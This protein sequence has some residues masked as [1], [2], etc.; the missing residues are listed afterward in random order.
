MINNPLRRSFPPSLSHV[1]T[2]NIRTP[3]LDMITP[4]FQSP[5]G[6]GGVS[7]NIMDKSAMSHHTNYTD[8]VASQSQVQKMLLDEKSRSE[9]HKINY[10]KLKKQTDQMSSEFKT[11]SY[12]LQ[13]KNEEVA[14]IKEQFN[15]VISGLESELKRKNQI[16]DELEGQALTEEKLESIKFKV[17]SDLQSTFKRRMLDMEQDVEKY[18]NDFNKLRHD[19]SFL[20][21]EYEKQAYDFAKNLED[22]NFKFVSEKN[23]IL[24][25][26][27]QIVRISEE[28]RKQSEEK[29]KNNV[30][31]N[32]YLK[33]RLISQ[34]SMNEE[35]QQQIDKLRND[36]DLRERGHIK[37]ITDHE[38]KIKIMELEKTSLVNQIEKLKSEANDQVNKMRDRDARMNEIERDNQ[39]LTHDNEVLTHQIS[40]KDGEIRLQM[41]K[42]ANYDSEHTLK[43][44]EQL[45]DAITEKEVANMQVEKF[46]QLMTSKEREFT[47]R[48]EKGKESHSI[49][50]NKVLEEKAELESKL[51]TSESEVKTLSDT[52]KSLKFDLNVSTNECSNLKEEISKLKLEMEQQKSDL[53]AKELEVRERVNEI[54]SLDKSSEEL[55]F[56]VKNLSSQF[57]TC[58]TAKDS[59]EKQN[60]KM[61]SQIRELET[62]LIT[63]QHT[64]RSQYQGT[65]QEWF[66]EK[67]KLASKI[68]DLTRENENYKKKLARAAKIHLS[69]KTNLREKNA[70]LKALLDESYAKIKFLEHNEA[71]NRGIPFEVHNQL[72]REF[73]ALVRR[74]D[75]FKELIH[76][77]NTYEHES[78]A[79]DLRKTDLVHGLLHSDWML[80][81]TVST[82]HNRTLEVNEETRDG[83][84][85]L[86]QW[87]EIDKMKETM[88][89]F[90][91]GQQKI[92]EQKSIEATANVNVFYDV[93]NLDLNNMNENQE[94]EER[95]FSPVP[96][97]LLIV[98]ERN[99]SGS[100]PNE[101]NFESEGRRYSE[102]KD[103]ERVVNDWEP[104]RQNSRSDVRDDEERSMTESESYKVTPLAS[105]EEQAL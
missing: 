3:V 96:N 104:E 83:D 4:T 71:K 9:K 13:A 34:Q 7:G 31:E 85:K 66:Q 32:A 53:N 92:Q 24:A 94:L 67:S 75:Q 45:E 10:E 81:D 50:L 99:V 49:E 2:V 21:S 12:E 26:K 79:Q 105:E 23:E 87:S 93:P 86:F 100:Q 44:K 80:N 68:A 11:Q 52:S 54:S 89:K 56:K 41:S 8:T 103:R 91:K 64:E 29:I 46:K 63:I 51:I 58:Q 61:D 70:K 55:Q 40:I 16:V 78:N 90:K 42:F 35:I 25:S 102:A 22:L 37:T 101:Q 36:S 97:N 47:R 38:A 57:E 20:K 43:L 74:H 76:A 18:R 17:I 6:F 14:R 60:L 72:K 1:P 39:R 48:L 15:V 84:E 77:R 88:Q 30:K 5:A 59:L 82:N 98:D 95:V 19:H 62:K 28:E 65:L 33:Q 73:K 69:M 27:E